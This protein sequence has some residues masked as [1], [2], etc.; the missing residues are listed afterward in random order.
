VFVAV[1]HF[2]PRLMFVGKA[3]EGIPVGVAPALPTNI[4]LRRKKLT[5][6]HTSPSMKIL[7]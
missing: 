2:H 5:V 1:S 7:D 6:R 4:R 3:L